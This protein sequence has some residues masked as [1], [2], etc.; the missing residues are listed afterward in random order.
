MPLRHPGRRKKRPA[1]HQ[2]LPHLPPTKIT[3]RTLAPGKPIPGVAPDPRSQLMAHNLNKIQDVPTL[4]SKIGMKLNIQRASSAISSSSRHSARSLSS[5]SS[6]NFKLARK[7]VGSQ[8]QS[9]RQHSSR[10]KR[11]RHFGHK[12]VSLFEATAGHQNL[13]AYSQSKYIKNVMS[14]PKYLRDRDDPAT[15]K[16]AHTDTFDLR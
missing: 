11:E 8:R 14:I 16:G 10:Q 13:Q 7:S 4:K 6:R 5:A 15:A 3:T 9:H 1:A 2:V 12:K